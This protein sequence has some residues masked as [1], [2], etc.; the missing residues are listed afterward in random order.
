MLHGSQ[1]IEVYIASILVLNSIEILAD[2]RVN[3]S[4]RGHLMWP[5]TDKSLILLG[6]LDFVGLNIIEN[7][8]QIKHKDTELITLNELGQSCSFT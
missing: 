7:H 5:E 2:K 8:Q 4:H 3:M 1:W 6:F